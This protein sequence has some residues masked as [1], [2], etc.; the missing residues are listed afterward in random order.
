MLNDPSVLVNSKV[1][2]DFTILVARMHII[3]G[4]CMCSQHAWR[5]EEVVRTS[6]I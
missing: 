6:G 2:I 5:P 1:Y 4:W 3:V